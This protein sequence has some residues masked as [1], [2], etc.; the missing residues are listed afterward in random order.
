M[1]TMSSSLV[2]LAVLV[3]TGLARSPIYWTAQGGDYLLDVEGF[4]QDFPRYLEL[5]H[6]PG[7]TGLNDNEY[8]SMDE[9]TSELQWASKYPGNAGTCVMA[10]EVKDGAEVYVDKCNGFQWETASSSS[11]TIIKPKGTNF[12]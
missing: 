4:T 5:W 9:T 10:K 7:H 12:C 2:A 1:G 6:R 3:P 11:G 8:F